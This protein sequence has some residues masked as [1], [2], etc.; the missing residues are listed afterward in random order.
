M[1]LDSS[2]KFDLNVAGFTY[3][4][5]IDEINETHNFLLDNF[6]VWIRCPECASMAT[7]PGDNE[8][9]CLCGYV[10]LNSESEGFFDRLGRNWL[11]Y[12]LDES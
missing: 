6:R 5:R 10:R 9:T 7:I 3:L 2:P 1:E 8:L 11:V 4:G 12:T